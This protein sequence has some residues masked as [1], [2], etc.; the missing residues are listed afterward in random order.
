[1]TTETSQVAGT[2]NCRFPPVSQTGF[3]FSL[4]FS[5][6]LYSNLVPAGS[7]SKVYHRGCFSVYFPALKARAL[8]T[9]QLPSCDI[10]PERKTSCPYL[11][12]L[13]KLNMIVVSMG[14]AHG[15][16]AV[17]EGQAVFVAV[18]QGPF[19]D[20]VEHARGSLA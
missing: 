5:T 18:L 7:L 3:L 13:R 12:G 8:L 6:Y 15:G 2:V 1:M 14:V 11:V 19:A 16:L 17:L 9:S 4:P 20:P 10:L